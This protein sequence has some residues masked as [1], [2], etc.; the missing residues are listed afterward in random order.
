MARH[1]REGQGTDQRGFSY[2]LSYQPDS[3]RQVKVTRTLPN[4]RQSTMALF[5]NPA[6]RAEATPGDQVRTR[7]IC[8]E[9]GLD[10]EVF[11]RA[12][13]TGVRQVQVQVEVPAARGAGGGS[14]N[15]VFTLDHDLPE[16]PRLGG[17]FR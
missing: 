8:A 6:E 13:G 2:I 4:G 17:V 12:N 9:Q 11:F 3:L 14:E 15:V 5:R 10:V 16:P 7:I 1:N